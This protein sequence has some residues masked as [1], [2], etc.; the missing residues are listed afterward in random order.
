MLLGTEKLLKCQNTNVLIGKRLHDELPSAYST[1]A[2]LK[3]LTYVA[4]MI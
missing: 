1:S 2:P 4:A 3:C